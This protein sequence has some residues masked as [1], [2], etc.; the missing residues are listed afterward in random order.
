[1]SKGRL[2]PRVVM[3]NVGRLDGKSWG[4][5]VRCD[6]EMWLEA[7]QGQREFMDTAVHE[8]LHLACREMGERKVRRVAGLVTG[9]L[10]RLGFREGRK[11]LERRKRMAR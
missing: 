8:A 3:V 4:W 6:R 9:V 10:W 2:K 7:R 11:A 1:M 5:A